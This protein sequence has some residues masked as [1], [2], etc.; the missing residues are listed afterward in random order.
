[1]GVIIEIPPSFPTEVKGNSVPLGLT[2][3]LLFY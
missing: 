1:M 2:V 3:L